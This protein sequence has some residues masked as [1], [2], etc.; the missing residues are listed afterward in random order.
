MVWGDLGVG[1]DHEI[2]GSS[3]SPSLS[4]TC[5]RAAGPHLGSQARI[6]APIELLSWSN[7]NGGEE[8]P[9]DTDRDRP[10]LG[11]PCL[12][13]SPPL[14]FVLVPTFLMFIL[15]HQFSPIPGLDIF[16]V[17]YFGVP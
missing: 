3:G 13:C 5:G 7:L 14:M 8:E 16:L 11:R 1:H 12:A 9:Q 4:L 17:P 10:G 2:P 6:T 15:L